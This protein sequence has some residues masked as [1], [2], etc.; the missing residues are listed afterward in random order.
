VI[1]GPHVAA[2]LRSRLDLDGFDTAVD[3]SVYMSNAAPSTEI[4]F[5]RRSVCGVVV[6][7]FFSPGAITIEPGRVECENLIG[8]GFVHT[9]PEIVAL[10]ARALPWP[11]ATVFVLR[12]QRGSRGYVW[13]RSNRRWLRAAF[14]DAGFTVHDRSAWIPVKALLGFP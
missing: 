10:R 6:W 7:F 8:G 4:G 14:L 1:T 9:H 12:T 2:S 11:G 3:T 5:P 13:P